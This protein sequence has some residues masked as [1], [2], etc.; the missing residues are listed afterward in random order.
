MNCLTLSGRLSVLLLAAAFAACSGGSSSSPATTT[1]GAS[2]PASGAGAASGTTPATGGGTNTGSTGS[3]TSTGAGTSSGSGTGSGTG[4]MGSNTGTGTGT[5]RQRHW[6]WHWQ[7]HQHRHGHQHRHRP[8]QQHRSRQLARR[9]DLSQRH[10]THRPAPERNRADPRD[11]QRDELRQAR[12]VPGRWRRRCRAALPRRREHR[13]RPHN[14]LYVATE[15]ASVYALDANTGATLW[16]TTTLGAGETPSD[17]HGCPQITPKIGITSTPVIDRTRGP[18]GA[19]YVVG[20]VEGR[21]GRVITSGFTRSTSRPAPNCSAARPRSPASYPGSGAKVRTARHVRSERNTPSAS[22]AAVE[23]HDLHR[24][25][26]ALRHP[27]LHRL[28]DR[29][30]RRHAQADWRARTSRRTARGGAIWMAG[31]GMAPTA[32]RSMSS[33]Q[34]APSTPTLNADGF[35]GDGDFGNGS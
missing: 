35:P 19:M 16:K 30:Q 8:G 5:I 29:L 2:S 6:H 10:R 31:A 21:L 9:R 18:H 25:D 20:D 33:T 3:G 28:G 15:N 17:D 22:V 14:V 23:R 11:R 27:A 1:T 26:F 4:S 32:R 13:G 12:R 34:T 24:L 7:R